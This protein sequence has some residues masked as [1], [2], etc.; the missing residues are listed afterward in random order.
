[1]THNIQDLSVRLVAVDDDGKEHPVQNHSVS[2]VGHYSSD[3]G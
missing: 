3:Y 1:M 2:G